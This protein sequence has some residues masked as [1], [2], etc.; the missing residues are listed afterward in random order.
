MPGL[1]DQ[2]AALIRQR[3]KFEHTPIIFLPPPVPLTPRRMLPEGI[4]W[5]R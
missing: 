3:K 1:D 5:E 2:T 4:A